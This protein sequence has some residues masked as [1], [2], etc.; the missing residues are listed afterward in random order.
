MFNKFKNMFYNLF[1]DS[2]V[3]NYVKKVSKVSPSYFFIMFIY[4]IFI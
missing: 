4:L 1:L 3:A 2:F